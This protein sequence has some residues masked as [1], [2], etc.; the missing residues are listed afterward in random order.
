MEIT[1]SELSS[2]RLDDQALQI[3]QHLDQKEVV[4]HHLYRSNGFKFSRAT[5]YRRLEELKM[6]GLI[7][8]RVGKARLTEKGLKL[9]SI[10]NGSDS[11]FKEKGEDDETSRGPHS[12]LTDERNGG[13]KAFRLYEAERL[14]KE[15]DESFIYV[16][17]PQTSFILNVLIGIAGIEEKL[18]TNVEKFKALKSADF[19][20]KLAINHFEN[21]PKQLLIF[22]DEL[23]KL[24]KIEAL[25]CGVKNE[26]KA[27]SNKKLV[28]FLKDHDFENER[29]KLPKESI[30]LFPLFLIGVI[31]LILILA[32]R[33]GYEHASILSVMMVVYFFRSVLFRE[34]REL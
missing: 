26:R 33:S 22:L 27:L 14:K 23:I 12:Y 28:E 2:M 5:F 32:L 20:V 34:L 18:K 29:F 30:T 19:K 16:D 17:Y 8:W 11:D 4:P 9:R 24:G 31:G 21:C 10:L 13:D 7:E 1:L 6:A 3:L 15:I 25:Y